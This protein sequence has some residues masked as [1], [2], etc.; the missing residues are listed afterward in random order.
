M[1]TTTSYFKHPLLGKELELLGLLQSIGM[2]LPTL[3]LVVSWSAST[4]GKEVSV[5]IKGS[6]V[7]I[8]AVYLHDVFAIKGLEW[9]G[10]LPSCSWL[11]PGKLIFFVFE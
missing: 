10:T 2:A 1:E 5:G 3:P 6:I 9:L 4:P 7:E 11:G 8:P